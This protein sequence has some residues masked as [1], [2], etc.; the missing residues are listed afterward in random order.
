MLKKIGTASRKEIE[1]MT[2]KKVYLQLRVKVR[3]NWRNDE[4]VLK[5][6]GY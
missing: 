5:W 3:Q 1:A 2:G 6:F 4:K